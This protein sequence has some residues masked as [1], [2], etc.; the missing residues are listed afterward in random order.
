MAVNPAKTQPMILNPGS[1]GK[2]TEI[3]TKGAII[4]HQKTMRLLGFTLKRATWTIKSG[5]GKTVLSNHF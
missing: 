4:K 1:G 3:E 2:D 5:V